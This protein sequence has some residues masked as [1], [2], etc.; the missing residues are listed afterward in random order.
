MTGRSGFGAWSHSCIR[1]RVR[2]QAWMR[3]EKITGFN[4]RTH[5][6]N[7]PLCT[8]AA[9]CKN[10]S[11]KALPKSSKSTWLPASVAS[12][13][14]WSGIAFQATLIENRLPSGLSNPYL[15]AAVTLAAGIDGIKNKIVPPPMFQ[16]GKRSKPPWKFLGLGKMPPFW[17]WTQTRRLSKNSVLEQEKT[18]KELWGVWPLGAKIITSKETTAILPAKGVEKDMIFNYNQSSGFASNYI[19][20]TATCATIRRLYLLC[21]VPFWCWR[22]SCIEPVMLFSHSQM[23]P[24]YLTRLRKLWLP[25]KMM[26]SWC[27]PWGLS[28]CD[29]L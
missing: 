29:G 1:E 28:S 22:W 7:P 25:W 17:R 20:R 23:L 15:A 18:L 12:T 2:V 11:P 10:Q 4:L 8:A 27:K 24:N 3:H 13:F 6:V 14:S 16:K 19:R 5:K 21:M 9:C 26:R